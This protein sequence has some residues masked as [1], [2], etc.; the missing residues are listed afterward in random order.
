[1]NSKKPDSGYGI[2]MRAAMRSPAVSCGAKAVY[3]YLCS[4]SGY[5]GVCYPSQS[6]IAHDLNL[7]V[8]TVRKYL[9]ELAE[10]RY[11]TAD[12]HRSECG[13]FERMTYTINHNHNAFT[14]SGKAADGTAID[15]AAAAGRSATNINNYNNNKYNNTNFINNN[16]NIPET[17]MEETSLEDCRLIEKQFMKCLD[18]F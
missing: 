16:T 9:R 7:H 15:G 2:V 13:R 10:N 14:A 12:R 3:A 5:D 11:I 4:F 18:R 8:G 6:L 1:M 17:C